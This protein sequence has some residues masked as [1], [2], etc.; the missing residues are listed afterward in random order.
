VPQRGSYPGSFCFGGAYERVGLHP[1]PEGPGCTPTPAFATP[2]LASRAPT[3]VFGFQIAES[4][5]PIQF[6]KV[7]VYV[8][9]AFFRKWANY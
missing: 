7:V 9:V 6:T 3:S 4:H 8:F 1:S 2:T 5:T